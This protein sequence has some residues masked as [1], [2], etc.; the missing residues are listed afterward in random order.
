MRGRGRRGGGLGHAGEEKEKGRKGRRPPGPGR[1]GEGKSQLG[2][3]RKGEMG[4]EKEKEGWAG[5]N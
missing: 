5:P 4:E 2:P 3:G 1:V